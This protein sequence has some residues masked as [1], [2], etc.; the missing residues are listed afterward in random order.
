MG[1]TQR[2]WLAPKPGSDDAEQL[3][4]RTAALAHGFHT[5]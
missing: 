3:R 2:E 4:R 5:Q 1:E